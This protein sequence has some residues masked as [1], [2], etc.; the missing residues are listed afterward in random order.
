MHVELYGLIKYFLRW[1]DIRRHVFGEN[2][3]K[4]KKK[5]TGS[6]TDAMC[7]TCFLSGGIVFK[8]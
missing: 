3:S 1:R 5:N 6:A 2:R 7:K 4:K 8:H